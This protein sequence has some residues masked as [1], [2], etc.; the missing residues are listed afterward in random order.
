MMTKIEIINETIKYYR[1]N[2]R[3]I[4]ANTLNSCQYLT[5]DGAMC[6]IGRCLINPQEAMDIGIGDVHDFYD[7]SGENLDSMLKPEYI[8]H[9]YDFWSDL[10]S[11]HDDNACWALDKKGN[12]LT[13]EGIFKYNSLLKIYGQS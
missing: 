11:F 5:E 4:K 1:T 8:G 3:G 6:A 12:K 7:E 2:L 10:Q 9:N 13:T